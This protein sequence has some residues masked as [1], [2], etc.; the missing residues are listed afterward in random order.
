VAIPIRAAAIAATERASR[1]RPGDTL[2]EPVCPVDDLI[3]ERFEEQYRNWKEGRENAS[4][5][6]LED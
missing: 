5:T 3:K 1:R 6:P 2:R 4:G